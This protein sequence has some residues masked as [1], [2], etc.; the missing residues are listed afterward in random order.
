[1][2][3]LILVKLAG[4]PQR[5]GEAKTPQEKQKEKQKVQGL[6]MHRVPSE[7]VSSHH[8]YNSFPEPFPYSRL[9]IVRRE[10]VGARVRISLD[11]YPSLW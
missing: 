7:L 6:H 5:T 3:S 1:M 10:G 2:S 8:P 11:I 4:G 9:P